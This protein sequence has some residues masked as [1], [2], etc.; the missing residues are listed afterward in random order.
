MTMTNHNVLA[1]ASSKE[2]RASVTLTR[3]LIVDDHEL[4]QQALLELINDQPD[5]EVCGLA[6]SIPDAL[7]AIRS[8]EPDLAIVDISLKGNNGLQLVKQIKS[9]EYPIKVLVV[10][11]HDEML[12]A[13]RAIRAGARGYI[14][15][16]EPAETILRAIRSVLEGNVYLSEQMSNR[17]LDKLISGAAPLEGS[18]VE[19]LSDRELEV[20]EL[21]GQGLGTRQIAE[22]LSL[23]TKTIESHREK[24]KRKLRVNG[25]AEL[26][27]HAIEWVLTRV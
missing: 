2:V 13:E 15:K 6:G 11:M 27:R 8:Q 10:S 25:G 3:V 16:Q 1:P 9:A 24:I 4:V 22:T 14:C 12:Y 26:A 20:F 23:S 21:I 17:L 18:L 7:R 19:S 5:L